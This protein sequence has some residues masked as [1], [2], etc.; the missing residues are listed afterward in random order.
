MEWWWR[1][2]SSQAALDRLDK[3]TAEYYDA[4]TEAERADDEEWA[5]VSSAAAKTLTID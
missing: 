3:E 2:A 4:L 1:R 5:N